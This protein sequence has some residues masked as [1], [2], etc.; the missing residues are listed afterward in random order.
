MTTSREGDPLF[1]EI[2][3][4]FEGL[5]QADRHG[6]RYEYVK[7]FIEAIQ[8]GL[9]VERAASFACGEWDL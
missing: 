9:S 2:D 3:P 8:E 6:L 4:F 5:L 7:S 1:Q